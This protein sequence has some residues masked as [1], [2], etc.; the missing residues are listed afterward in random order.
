VK[1]AI[2]FRK[3]MLVRY[4]R[5]RW[6]AVHEQHQIVFPEG[7]LVLNEAGAAIVRLCDGRSTDDLIT[8][9]EEQF[10]SGTWA[11]HVCNFFDRLA[12]KGLLH[13]AADG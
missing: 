5:F 7:V 9:L 8:S 3:P 11:E 13:D 12:K 10:K 1:P 6:D 4:A 2:E